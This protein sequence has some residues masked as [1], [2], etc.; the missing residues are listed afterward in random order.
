MTPSLAH[1]PLLKDATPEALA[2][3]QAHVEWLSLP[4]GWPLFEVGD[5]ADYLYFVVSG[6]LGA[7]R[8]EVNGRRSLIGHIR[9][10]EPV[11]EMALVAGEPH[12]AAVYALRDTELL[13]LSRPAFNRLIRAHPSL[14]QNLARIML[15]RN[16]QSK[17][18][19]ARAEPKVY[20]LIS[21]SPTIDLKLR[22]K[23]LADALA[24]LGKK[25]AVV[26]EDTAEDMFSLWLDALEQEH[27]AVLLLSPVADNA[28]FRICLRQADRI[29]IL[30]RSDARPSIP[31]LPDDPS[32]ARHFRLVDT[33]M[34]HHGADRP[35][36]NGE[37]WRKACEADRLF[38]WHG[39][40]DRDCARLARVIAGQAVGLVFSGG[41]AR[42]YAHIGVLRAMREAGVPVDSVGGASM[43][44]IVAGCYAMGWA[45]DEI[46]MRIRKAF[47]ESNPLGD[48]V[49]PVLALSKGKRVD[50]R[51]REH[52]GEAL[53]EDLH[54]P[55]FCVSTN[56]MSGQ[57]KVHRA[58]KLREALR[59]SI[60]LPGILPPVI[61]GEHGVLVDGAVLKNFPVDVMRGVH[62]GAIIGVDVAQKSPMNPADFVDTPDFFGWVAQH[63]LQTPPPIAS[64]LMRAATLTVDP[65]QGRERTD[66]LITPD[67]PNVDL[68]DWKKFDECVAAGYEAAVAALKSQHIPGKTSTDPQDHAALEE[69][70]H[71]VG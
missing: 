38:H 30:A 56:L 61:D 40:N 2:D 57:L 49:L 53:I 65:W 63:G 34:L 58:G 32:P 35:A 37:D 13:R 14:M 12:T 66:V 71:P 20:A 55:F 21:T 45:D 44:G 29:W 5:T 11:G 67:M 62:R 54:T 43:G 25:C 4:A 27:D 70:L 31:L 7:F 50:D 59:A 23:A 41:G 15:L 3:A 52:F 17:R 47:V 39:L 68:R 33:V 60:S 1:I 9:S 28:W 19:N 64:V 6:A 42:A 48:Y 18:R 16:R 24:K 22:A 46:E 51:L 69:E 36:S 8:G 10:G 26:S